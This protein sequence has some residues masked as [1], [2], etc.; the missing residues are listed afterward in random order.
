MQNQLVQTNIS[1]GYFNFK[2]RDVYI[3]KIELG[4][5]AKVI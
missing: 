3:G 4:L 2:R 1:F 5:K